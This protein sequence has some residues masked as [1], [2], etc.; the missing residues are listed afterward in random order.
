MKPSSG[1]SRLEGALAAAESGA[2]LTLMPTVVASVLR[3]VARPKLFGQ[4]TPIADA[5]DCVDPILA[6]P[7]V[8][9]ALLGTEWPKQRPLRLDKP[10]PATTCPMRGWPPR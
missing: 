6:M 10:R 9:R 7:G 1:R 5:L 8:R 3:L 2:A 4:P